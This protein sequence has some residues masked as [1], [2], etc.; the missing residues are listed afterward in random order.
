MPSPQRDRL[1]AASQPRQADRI[2]EKAAG[3][4][5]QLTRAP[6]LLSAQ[7]SGTHRWGW[8]ARRRAVCARGPGA[9]RLC[10]RPRD[11]RV[12]ANLVAQ[13]EA[14]GTVAPVRRHRA[15][16]DRRWR[17][18][19]NV[20]GDRH[21]ESV[22]QPLERSRNW[23]ERIGRAAKWL[24]AVKASS[25]EERNRQSPALDCAAADRALVQRLAA[26]IVEMQRA[27]WR[28]GSETGRSRA[29][30][31]QQ[32]RPCNAAK[33][34]LLSTQSNPAFQKGCEVPSLDA[35]RRR[36]PGTCRSRA[37]KFQPYFESGFPYGH[38][39]W[40]SAMG[41]GWATAALAMALP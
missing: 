22:R 8:I 23:N 4:R 27:G 36:H 24:T 25:A 9:A 38:D 11:R 34:G 35:A 3:D 40:I 33:D 41:T 18:L 6:H 10:A 37:P 28:L 17:H 39:Q 29:T 19:R 32:G 26:A 31:T 13:Q 7:S 2:D 5:L 15:S 21:D 30:P 1:V 16:S 14:D 20:A 12:V